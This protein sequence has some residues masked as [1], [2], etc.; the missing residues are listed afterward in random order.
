MMKFCLEKVACLG[1]TD[2]TLPFAEA[3]DSYRTDIVLENN[4]THPDVIGRFEKMPHILMVLR[5]Q[6]HSQCFL[7]IK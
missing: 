3:A 2:G 1:Q 4:D 5:P 6:I 7:K